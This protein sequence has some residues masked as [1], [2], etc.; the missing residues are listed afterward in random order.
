MAPSEASIWHQLEARRRSQYS[1]KGSPCFSLSMD[2][3]ERVSCAWRS[4]ATLS[5][6]TANAGRP[7]DS[8]DEAEVSAASKILSGTN[9]GTP[10]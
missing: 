9:D 6:S 5:A 4:D 1:L 7:M 2:V 3:D 10:L 8:R